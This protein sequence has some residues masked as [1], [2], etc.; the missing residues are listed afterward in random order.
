MLVTLEHHIKLMFTTENRRYKKYNVEWRVGT[1]CKW[2]TLV[3][4]EEHLKEA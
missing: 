4:I 3:S 1:Y 2:I